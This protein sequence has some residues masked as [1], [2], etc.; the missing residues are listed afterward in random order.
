[1]L[2]GKK[3]FVYPDVFK[4]INKLDTTLLNIKEIE[5]GYYNKTNYIRIQFCSIISYG[6]RTP[7]P[8]LFSVFTR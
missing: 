5:D 1:M 4:A 3:C 8:F 6:N 2:V 7:L